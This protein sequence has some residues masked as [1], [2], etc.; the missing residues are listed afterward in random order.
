MVV[1][2]VQDEDP[3]Q[4]KPAQDKTAA[5]ATGAAAGAAQSAA[6]RP[7][8][9]PVRRILQA[10]FVKVPPAVRKTTN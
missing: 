8:T 6:A 2:F 4:D 10:A 7:E 3:A 9:S 1:A 5:P